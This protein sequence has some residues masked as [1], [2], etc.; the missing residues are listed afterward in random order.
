[1]VVKVLGMSN[2]VPLLE[3]DFLIALCCGGSSV[4]VVLVPRGAGG[5]RDLSPL[6]AE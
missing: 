1:M 2:C 3:K 4:A 5:G 6:E